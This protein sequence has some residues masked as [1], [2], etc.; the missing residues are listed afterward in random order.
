[1]LVTREVDLAAEVGECEAYDGISVVPGKRTVYERL[2]W[3]GN[4]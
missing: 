4:P 3:A 2:T 1:M